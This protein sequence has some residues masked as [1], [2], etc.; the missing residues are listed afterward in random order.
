MTHTSLN[1]KII[2]HSV[3]LQTL[4]IQHCFDKSGTF[5]KGFVIYSYFHWYVISGKIIGFI[6]S[7]YTS[8]S[9]IANVDDNKFDWL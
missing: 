4:N 1:D 8:I 6:L 2:A 9:T 7:A 3:N 5:E